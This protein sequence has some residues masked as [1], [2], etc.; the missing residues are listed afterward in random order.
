[1]PRKEASSAARAVRAVGDKAITNTGTKMRGMTPGR[2]P[3]APPPSKAQEPYTSSSPD[4]RRL[5]DAARAKGKPKTI[6][7]RSRPY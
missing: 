3:A 1:M 4:D 6:K 5:M 2:A 7:V